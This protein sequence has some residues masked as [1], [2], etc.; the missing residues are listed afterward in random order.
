MENKAGLDGFAQSHFVGEKDAADMPRRRFAGDIQLV[1][2][3]VDPGPAEPA[4]RRS[5]EPVP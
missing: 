5:V 2:D 3:E 4:D 1:R